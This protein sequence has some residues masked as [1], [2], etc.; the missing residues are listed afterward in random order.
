M[1][2]IREEGDDT[3]R[4]TQNNVVRRHRANEMEA[5]QKILNNG[6]DW[7]HDLGKSGIG[8]ENTV[9]GGRIDIQKALPEWGMERKKVKEN[10]RVGRQKMELKVGLHSAV[11]F[12]CL[13]TRELVRDLGL[14]AGRFTKGKE[15]YEHN[16]KF[17]REGRAAE[18]WTATFLGKKVT[19]TGEGEDGKKGDMRST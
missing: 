15:K 19:R 2:Q 14:S 6:F 13:D 7:G 8:E 18:A 1:D 5:Y 11:F 9:E 12:K 16:A 3:N 17:P 4:C 10:N